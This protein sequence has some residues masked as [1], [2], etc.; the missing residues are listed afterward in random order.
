MA[1]VALVVD[2]H[3]AGVHLDRRRM[4]GNKFFFAFGEGIVDEDWHSLVVSPREIS[5]YLTRGL[6]PNECNE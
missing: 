4:K 2:G 6:I 3:T 1:D 5:C